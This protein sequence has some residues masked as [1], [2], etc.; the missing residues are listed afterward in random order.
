[1]I[2]SKGTDIK[3]EPNAPKE[4]NQGYGIDC[5]GLVN[6]RADVISHDAR[7][8]AKI[9]KAEVKMFHNPDPF[10]TDAF[11]IY[12]VNWH[13]KRTLIMIDDAKRGQPDKKAALAQT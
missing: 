11:A 1:V 12:S 7:N 2:W 6:G 3:I 5:V 8:I 9:H 4:E 13:R 10:P